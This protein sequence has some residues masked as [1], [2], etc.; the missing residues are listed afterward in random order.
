MEK[1]MKSYSDEIMKANVEEL[2]KFRD[3][4]NRLISFREKEMEMK[5]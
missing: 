1:N 5:K 2:I 3:S 4:I